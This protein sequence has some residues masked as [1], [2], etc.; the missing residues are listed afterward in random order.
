MI[1][2]KVIDGK[3]YDTRTA[4]AVYEYENEEDGMSPW[5][6]ETLYRKRTGEYFLY[7][8][9]YDGSCRYCGGLIMPYTLDAAMLWAELHCDGD[10]YEEIFGEVEE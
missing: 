7:G 8:E 5:Y 4:K 2:S 10:E 3:M 9:S 6:R 1:K